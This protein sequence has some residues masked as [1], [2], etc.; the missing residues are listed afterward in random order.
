MQIKP[1]CVKGADQDRRRA[2]PITKCEG[3]NI[4][5]WTLSA[6]VC[7]RSQCIVGVHMCDAT[8][9]KKGDGRYYFGR[10]VEYPF[11]MQLALCA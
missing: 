7:E 8:N 2:M 1:C 5:I 9:R 10:E 3:K 6:V 11:I 4:G